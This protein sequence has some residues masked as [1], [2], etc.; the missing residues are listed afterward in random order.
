M[1]KNIIGKFIDCVFEW[2][3]NNE[4]LAVKL[5]FFLW[6]VNDIKEKRYKNKKITMLNFDNT[7]VTVLNSNRGI[8]MHY[9]IKFDNL[10]IYHIYDG[11]FSLNCKKIACLHIFWF[12]Y[13]SI[14]LLFSMAQKEN[15]KC[16]AKK[17]SL[18][19]RLELT[20]S[21]SL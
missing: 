16:R 11:I 15:K 4:K 17:D 12:F 2:W 10:D 6:T 8:V 1:R 5:K 19:L 18:V 7:P 21:L 3:K 13:F 14:Y 20:L 9:S